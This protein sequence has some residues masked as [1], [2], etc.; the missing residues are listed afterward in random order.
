M[1]TASNMKKVV[2]DDTDALAELPQDLRKDVIESRAEANDALGSDDEQRR[3]AATERL[4]KVRER[5]ERWHS[6]RDVGRYFVT[7]KP[8]RGDHAVAD[9]LIKRSQDQ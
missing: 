7:M 2:R 6:S 5:V 8:I 9:A 1:Q 4:A 3:A